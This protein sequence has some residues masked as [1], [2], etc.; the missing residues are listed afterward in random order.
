MI[1]YTQMNALHIACAIERKCDYFI[2]TDNGLT[3]KT[4]ADIRIRNPI[5]FVREM[6]DFT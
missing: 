5:D 6:E 4:I 2:T 3:S 1:Y